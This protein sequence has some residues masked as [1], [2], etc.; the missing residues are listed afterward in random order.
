MQVAHA[1]QMD[2]NDLQERLLSALAAGLRNPFTQIARKAELARIDVASPEALTDIE[3]IA[4]NAQDLIDGYLLCLQMKESFPLEP[5]AIGAV[6]NDAAHLLSPLG[7]QY[8]CDIELHVRGRTEPVLIHR[9]S[10][11]AALLSLGNV[12]I[13]A[14]ATES[15]KRRPS[16]KLGSH[17]SRGG[18]VAGLFTA[19]ETPLAMQMLQRGKALL[20]NVRRPLP[21]YSASSGAAVYLADAL[22][23]H[24]SGGLRVAQ[25]QKL[26]GLAATF[27]PARQLSLV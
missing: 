23:A 18:T 27:A 6:L 22:L 20:G 8:N 25:H 13:E 5:V 10:L 15:G 14:Q 16:V 9:R 4:D 12:F 1:D 19:T 21:Q 24:M 26:T 2:S 7:R 11:Q 17:R 3:T